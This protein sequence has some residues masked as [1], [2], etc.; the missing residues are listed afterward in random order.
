MAEVTPAANADQ[1]KAW[2]GAEGEDW[3]TWEDHYNRA[4][5]GYDARLLRAAAIQPADRVL[6]I[7]CGTGLSTR[8]AAWRATDGF[9]LGVDLSAR[10][11]ARA[12]ERAHDDGLTNTGFL[13][14]DA[15]AHPFEAGSFDAAIS[16]FGAMFFD[17]P[18]AAFT[19]IGRALRASGRLSLLAW[20]PLAAN[21]W[22][23]V[24]RDAV[25]AGR[26]L[27]EPPAGVPGPFGLADPDTA[28]SVLTG[29]G[30]AG[31][32]IEAVAAAVRLGNDPDDAFG[33]VRSMGLCRGLLTGLDDA[34]AAASL[35]NLRAALAAAQTGDGVLLPSAAWLITAQR[36]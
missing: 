8:Q 35:Q 10:M 18:L 28:T 11:L 14:A 13:R 7:G 24:I 4:V 25:A 29:S 20:Q 22:V 3:T 19:N 31:I 15:Q 12:R 30:F 36:A 34:T 21:P 33:Y 26:Q 5:D 27:P 32:T 17:D 16:R 9:A 6:D 2:D 1:I 23:Q